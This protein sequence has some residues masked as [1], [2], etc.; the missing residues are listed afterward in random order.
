M[1][2]NKIQQ[3]ENTQLLKAHML[4]HC[5]PEALPLNAAQN[6]RVIMVALIKKP[7]CDAQLET[8]D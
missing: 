2:S 4:H 1:F 8:R 7:L 5:L 3:K 6:L